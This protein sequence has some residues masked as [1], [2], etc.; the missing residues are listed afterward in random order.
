[1]ARKKAA[2]QETEKKVDGKPPFHI[3]DNKFPN[4]RYTLSQGGGWDTM[5]AMEEKGTEPLAFHTQSAA[6]DFLDHLLSGHGVVM[7]ASDADKG[8]QPKPEPED[9]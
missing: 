1:M 9:D 4:I 3:V 7:A 8:I 6:E 5:A 2:A